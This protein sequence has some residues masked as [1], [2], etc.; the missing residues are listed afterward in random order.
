VRRNGAAHI[1]IL[2]KRVVSMTSLGWRPLPDLGLVRQNEDGEPPGVVTD[3][4]SDVVPV[5]TYSNDS[6]DLAGSGRPVDRPSGAMLHPR[7]SV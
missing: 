1:S 4:E 6:C 2:G 7:Q 5:L 3:R